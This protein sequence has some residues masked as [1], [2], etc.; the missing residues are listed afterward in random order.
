MSKS[1]E[2]RKAKA[3]EPMAAYVPKG[4]RI[5]EVSCGSGGELLALRKRGYE[6]QG[7]N[8][9]RYDEELPDL[10]VE[11]GVDI[12]E[13]LP[14]ADNT[15]DGVMLL[16][17]IEHLRNHDRAVA[18][19]AR[20]C[21]DG[22]C[23]LVMTPN[24]M[25]LTSRLH[26]LFSGFFKLKRAFIGFDVAPPDAFTFHNYPPH[27][28]T[29][30]Y[31]IRS[32]GLAMEQFATAGYKAKSFLYW[33]LLVPFVWLATTLT[34]KGEKNLKGTPAE[35]QLRQVLTSFGGLCGEFWFVLAR[36][37]MGAEEGKTALPHW[38]QRWRDGA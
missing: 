16:D 9:T 36:K 21:K 26:F 19:L 3:V 18:E 15:F 24:T 2:I 31:Q 4:G 6:V 35:R 38:S 11:H 25:K 14:F 12:I 27:L 30:L 37:T 5:L 7:T 32:R 8:Y 22:G 17:V 23:V 10:P 13:G 34:L 28:P 33:L 20:V 29:F 1:S